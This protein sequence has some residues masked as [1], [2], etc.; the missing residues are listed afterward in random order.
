MKFKSSG[1]KEEFLNNFQTIDS[2]DGDVKLICETKEFHCH[3]FLLISQ[4]PVFKAMFQMESKEKEQNVV[5]IVDCAPEVVEEFVRYLYKGVMLSSAKPLELMFGLLNLAN[6]YQVDLLKAECVDVL[7]DMM[8]VDNVLRIFAVVDKIDPQSDV[9]DMVIDFVKKN[10][11]V[12]VKKEDWFSFLSDYPSLATDFVL[13]MH[14]EL[15]DRKDLKDE[16]EWSD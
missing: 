3:K 12:I 13:N 2:A 15:N 1:S 11:K 6:K 7:M 8:D 16:D 10:L 14:Q 9:N 4:S 5:N